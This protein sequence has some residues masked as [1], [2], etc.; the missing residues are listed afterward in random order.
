[1]KAVGLTEFEG[2]GSL[3]LVDRDIPAVEPGTVRIRMRAATVNPVD[4]GFVYGGLREALQRSRPPYVPGMEGA[5]EIDAVGEGIDDLSVGDRVSAIALPFGRYGGAQSEYVVVKRPQVIATPDHFTDVEAAT[6]PMNGLTAQVALDL[7]DLPTGASL[8]V[9]G[10]P[11]ALGGYTVQLAKARGLRV[12]ADVAADDEVLVKELGAEVIV[13]RGPD[14][15]NEVYDATDGVTGIVDA[16]VIGASVQSALM[17]GG[18]AIVA[19]RPFDGQPR[20]NVTIHDLRVGEYA[21][22]LARL[23]PALENN[24][25]TPRI[26]EVVPA[27][28]APRAYTMVERGGLRGRVVLGL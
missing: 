1:M 25:L 11:G 22:E 12:V 26:T 21:R 16:A 8:W 2:P 7:L 3:Q 19:V 5:G 27:A 28:D 20:A 24:V 23:G 4:V 9:T 18:G 10:A 14:A 6:I 15:A 13:H 17:D